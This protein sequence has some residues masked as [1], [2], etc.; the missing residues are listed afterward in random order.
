MQGRRVGFLSKTGLPVFG[1]RHGTPRQGCEP[2]RSPARGAGASAATAGDCHR[3]STQQ[4]VS[5]GIVASRTVATH[6]AQGSRA[7]RGCVSPHQ[8]KVSAADLSVR[9]QHQ[10]LHHQN[11]SWGGESSQEGQGAPHISKSLL[12]LKLNV[13]KVESINS[14]SRFQNT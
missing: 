2:N 10:E 4:R 9:L 13:V 14:W 1:K 7:H 12:F 3:L 5:C 6:H 11:G 8:R